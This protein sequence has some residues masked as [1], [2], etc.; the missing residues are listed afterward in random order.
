MLGDEISSVASYSS[1]LVPTGLD[2]NVRYRVGV[3]P[4]AFVA[5]HVQYAGS[6]RSLADDA[7][8]G[9]RPDLDALVY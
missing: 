5:T 2:V 3:V 1:P 7:A 4:Q 9:V 6:S 8:S